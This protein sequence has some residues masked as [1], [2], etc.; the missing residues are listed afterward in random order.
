MKDKSPTRKTARS[1]SPGGTLRHRQC[2]SPPQNGSEH[3]RFCNNNTS[4]DCE[5]T[6]HHHQ[7][8]PSGGANGS[9]Q[10]CEYI[11]HRQHSSS[12]ECIK[13][14]LVTQ[15]QPIQK[16]LLRAKSPRADHNNKNSPVVNGGNL[17]SY[18][19]CLNPFSNAVDATTA[20]QRHELKLA[21][22]QHKHQQQNNS[23]D[24]RPTPPPLPPRPH[25]V[26][27]P[28][29]SSS[30]VQ[31]KP[32]WL[33]ANEQLY[34]NGSAHCERNEEEKPVNRP[35]TLTGSA[36]RV[37]GKQQP[38][39]S[40][41]GTTELSTLLSITSHLPSAAGGNNTFSEVLENALREMD[42][43]LNGM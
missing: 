15:P 34:V 20:V 26:A 14:L 24:R 6:N 10:F 28:A 21:A 29:A 11:T 3:P 38:V 23:S 43:I 35:A 9:A 19:P 18:P 31:E 8:S 16:E 12:S 25:A 1:P 7:R 17:N 32:H 36:R 39:E 22:E 4:D 37:T 2:N 33:T 27:S 30:A 40:V 5:K 13:K 41:G 42:D